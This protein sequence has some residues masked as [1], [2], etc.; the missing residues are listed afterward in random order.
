MDKNNKVWLTAIVSVVVIIAVFIL[1]KDS[2][3]ENGLIENQPEELANNGEAPIQE[4]I[5]VEVDK[6]FFEEFLKANISDISPEKEVLGGKFYLTSIEW[7]N[8]RTAII[9]YEDGH[10]ALKAEVELSFTDET[11]SQIQ[12]ERFEMMELAPPSND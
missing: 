11:K 8:D 2:S 6:V 1:M 10:I 12:V 3:E 5:Y 9:E 7:V 4:I